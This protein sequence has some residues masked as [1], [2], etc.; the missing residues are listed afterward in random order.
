MSLRRISAKSKTKTTTDSIAEEDIMDPTFQR[1][2]SK[3]RLDDTSDPTPLNAFDSA[4]HVR[5]SLQEGIDQFG[6]YLYKKSSS[7]HS[8]GRYYGSDLSE[9]SI[10]NALRNYLG[11]ETFDACKVGGWRLA[12]LPQS[13]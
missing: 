4:Q 5:S 9:R 7:Q 10:E 2:L 6:R 13:S 3:T 1:K 12:R 11:A 8:R